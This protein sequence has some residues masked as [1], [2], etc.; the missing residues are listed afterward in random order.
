MCF[1]V[2]KV[3]MYICVMTKITKRF[4]WNRISCWTSILQSEN[5]NI[6][7]NDL[8]KFCVVSR[9]LPLLQWFSNLRMIH[10]YKTR[11][12][13][14]LI[15]MLND[16]SESA[17]PADQIWWTD[18]RQ[19]FKLSKLNEHRVHKSIFFQHLISFSEFLFSN[20]PHLIPFCVSQ[21][22]NKCFHQ[23]QIVSQPTNFLNFKYHHHHTVRS[24]LLIIRKVK[25]VHLST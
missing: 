3:I 20:M 23:Q 5:L 15:Q 12:T 24:L 21:K 1:C 7:W 22:S 25:H 19:R 9:S 6:S 18:V 8:R 10:K 4:C 17:N 11:H 14:A 2:V 16:K 13:L